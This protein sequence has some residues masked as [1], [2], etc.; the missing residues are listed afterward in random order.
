MR[1][2]QL[3]VRVARG[4]RK[5]IVSKGG[6]AAPGVNQD[7][8]AALAGERD[9]RLDRRM[10]EREALG[11]RMELDPARPGR[12]AAAR[13]GERV[14]V[15]VDATEREKATVRCAGGRDRLVVGLRV[16]AGLVHREADGA[17][18]R[19]LEGA[20]QLIRLLAKAVGVVAPDVGVGVKERERAG[21][22]SHRL[23]PFARDRLERLDSRLLL[24]HAP[25]PAR[26]AAPPPRRAPG[27]CRCSGARSLL[28]AD[29]TPV[30]G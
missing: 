8:D 10:V 29:R 6:N 15:R 4:E 13:L 21:A 26:S 27:S 19:A 20:D 12:E 9:E 1:E 2:D 22:L 11:T 14:V 3:R 25:P 16:A 17:R 18:V 30:P 23:E 28:P 7:R 5:G 24:S